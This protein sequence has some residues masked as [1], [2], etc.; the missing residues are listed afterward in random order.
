M[1]TV[2][3]SSALKTLGRTVSFYPSLA[4]VWGIKESLFICQ[5]LYWTPRSYD[6]DG[7][8]YKTAEE[9]EEEIGLTYKEQIRARESLRD[10][11]VLE[12]K[13]NRT[14]HRIYF[15][16]NMEALK[17][18]PVPDE[19]S[20][21]HLTKGKMASDERSTGTLPKVIS[22]KGTE[23]TTEITTHS[24][25]YSF[26]EFR[27]TFSGRMGVSVSNSKSMQAKFDAALKKLDGK[28]LRARHVAWMDSAQYRYRDKREMKQWAVKNFFDDVY[29]FELPEPEKKKSYPKAIP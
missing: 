25:G 14:E 26:S 28:E 17:A 3:F 18:V 6:E 5:L 13:Q 27:K 16:L 23:I 1:K 19:R 11:G 29:D 2:D 22:Y 8:V 20:D 4:K 21:E 9:W 12:E 10:A 7:W 24:N 15:R